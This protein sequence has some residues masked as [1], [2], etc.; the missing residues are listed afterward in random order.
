MNKIGSRNNLIKELMKVL[1]DNVTPSRIGEALELLNNIKEYDFKN[2]VSVYFYYDEYIDD[3]ICLT[4]NKDEVDWD[5]ELI[6][7][8][9]YD[10]KTKSFYGHIYA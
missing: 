9:V 10:E 1:G 6:V 7:E 5:T 4:E 8:M 3:V 2:D